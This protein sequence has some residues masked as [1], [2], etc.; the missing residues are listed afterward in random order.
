MQILR[1]LKLKP[2]GRQH[3]DPTRPIEVPQHK[4]QL[5]PGYFTSISPNQKGIVLIADVAHKVLRTGDHF[6]VTPLNNCFT[7]INHYLYF[8]ESRYR[9][10]FPD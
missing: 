5:W 6:N 3:F 9:V 8:C 10:G 2:I 4:V 1:M 7:R